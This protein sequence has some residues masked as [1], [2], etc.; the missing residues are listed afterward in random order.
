MKYLLAMVAVMAM[1]FAFALS[2]YNAR[3]LPRESQEFTLVAPLE[4]VP[5]EVASLGININVQTLLT[6]GAITALYIDETNG[7][8]SDTSL[9]WQT[10]MIGEDAHP[11]F[12]RPQMALLL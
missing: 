5:I 1:L 2:T 12:Y 9:T 7:P 6:D 4:K 3:D 8:A 11:G 10:N